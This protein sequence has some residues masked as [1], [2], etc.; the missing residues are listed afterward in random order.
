MVMAGCYWHGHIQRKL[1]L[2]PA[3]RILRPQF[4]TSNVSKLGD[5]FEE[6][7]SSDDTVGGDHQITINRHQ[8]A[9]QVC[10]KQKTAAQVSHMSSQLQQHIKSSAEAAIQ[11]KSRIVA[12]MSHEIREYHT[13]AHYT[14]PHYAHYI[15]HTPPHYT[16][17]YHTLTS[18]AHTSHSLQH[19]NT[20]HLITTRNTHT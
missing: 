13:T 8:L 12:C 6:E 7:Q 11:Q 17:P 19:V 14:P 3:R 18:L 15:L 1:L 20:L 9:H 10:I 2:P 16:T 5:K 4:P